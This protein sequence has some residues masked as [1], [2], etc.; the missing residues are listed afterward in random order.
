MP[1]P[2]NG[3][4]DVSQCA[5]VPSKEE[6]T[7]CL[8]R[9]DAELRDA[10]ER[11][12]SVGQQLHSMRD[13]VV[14]QTKPRQGSKGVAAT[15]GSL[16]LQDP[17]ALT[18]H[19]H[20]MQNRKAQPE[21]RFRRASGSGAQGELQL[22]LH[23][24]WMELST[25]AGAEVT[26]KDKT[27][28][29]KEAL[30]TSSTRD[31]LEKLMLKSRTIKVFHPQGFFK[32]CWD[33][34]ALFLLI[35]DAITIPPS[36]AWDVKMTQPTF[37]GWY[38]MISFWMS[39]IFWSFDF[40]INLNTAVY[41]KGTLQSGRDKI[42]W[43]YLTTWMP[44]DLLLIGFD[45]MF[46][47]FD[48]GDTNLAVVR[49]ARILRVLRMIRLIKL[50]KL[51]NL[52][53]ESAAA[54]GRQW[55]T[56]VVAITKTGVGMILVAHWLTCF[57]YWTGMFLVDTSIPNWIEENE[58][59]LVAGWIQYL[60]ALRWI[61]N[62]PSPPEIHPAS[63]VE[64]A[65]DIFISVVTLVVIGS[66]ISKISGTMA[67]L[68][69]MNEETS[70]RR[71]EVRLY[72]ASQAVSY[73]LV[74]RI[75][76]F[77]DYKLEKVS[78]NNMDATLISPTLQL[79]LYINQRADYLSQM[80][81]FALA[82]ECYPEVFGSLCA[83]FTK[84]FYEKGESVFTAGSYATA[85]HL[86]YV[87]KYEYAPEHED[88][89]PLDSAV[90]WFGELS[91][92]V[93]P[94]WHSS[95]LTATSFAETFSLQGEDLVEC[96]KV[97][98]GCTSMFCE[99]AKDFLAGM[100]KTKSK[101]G[102][103]DQKIQGDLCC[104]HNQHFQAAYPDPTTLFKNIV[105]CRDH[106]SEKS[107]E[108]AEDDKLTDYASE[109]S[110]LS[111]LSDQ[112]GG[113][114]SFHNLDEIL[115][116][117]GLAHFASEWISS[118][119]DENAVNLPQKLQ[120]V[121]PELDKE[122][123]THVVFGQAPE[124]DR[125][126]SACISVL[127]LVRN[128]YDVFTKPQADNV[129]LLESQ[130]LELQQIVSWIEPEPEELHAVLVLLAIRGLGKS[131]AVMQQ[132]PTE[133]RRPERAVIHLS[134]NHQNVIPSTRWLTEKGRG[135][136]EE[137]LLTH[138]LFNL[139]QMLQGE[140]CP[141]NVKELHAHIEEKGDSLFR[142]YILFL[143]GFMSGL[144]G[145]EGSRFMNAKNADAT[146]GGIRVLQKLM[147]VNA[148]AIYWGYLN[149]RAEKLG[150][151]FNDPEDLVLVRLACL[152]RVQDQ[153]GYESLRFAWLALGT[154]E[155]SSLTDHFLADGIEERAFNLEFLPN[156]VGNAKANPLI[157]LTLLLDVLTDL[158]ASLRTK[159]AMNPKMPKLVSVDLSDMGE[160]ISAV[161]NRFVFATC[162][163]R[164]QMKFHQGRVRIEMT[165]G[166][167]GRATD[168]DSDLTSI[169]YTLQ[170]LVIK[171]QRLEERL[172]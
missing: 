59:S 133:L 10:S 131:K 152:A 37:G 14:G 140:N 151:P 76:R 27:R 80:P 123:G 20:Q 158:L 128:K 129:K 145:G 63:G 150:L 156:C 12:A 98:R 70:R 170:D 147:S 110:V 81:I 11:L 34:I 90:R 3:V 78:A 121:I 40:P 107:P 126:E 120:V 68:R 45:Y 105:I 144:A 1:V 132:V 33:I 26:V 106:D 82:Q 134:Q 113:T 69:A 172:L 7:Q 77:V 155:R 51:N 8:D 167:W 6:L 5:V 74:T 41:V 79:E 56:M 49:S 141:A 136:F 43:M 44:F 62:A 66:A 47:S 165:G 135:L 143:L 64:R 164:C 139:A 87:G 125:G 61:L 23:G 19:Q 15:S 148:T 163:S 83:A 91:L 94:S 114:R 103:E 29:F 137:A 95:T 142:F 88:P 58:A 32:L 24:R 13:V 57:W 119:Q 30:S 72:L 102:D 97:N 159:A 109:K 84:T 171:Q 25:H 17:P 153:K 124:R 160:F 16:L 122:F 31:D 149:L 117:Q 116:D 65:V 52:I 89:R 99:Y 21:P 60:H 92:Y 118:D 71:R 86:T 115:E 50:S 36:L 146:I 35:N 54:A 38:V 85:L 100:Q 22:R 127:A 53:E 2:S 18:L 28:K 138:E 112:S 111:R 166:N 104:R 168:S 169:A 108:G 130:W 101:F 39:L 4:S 93:D 75:M 157:G 161:R 96:I 48:L 42:L 67:E 162:I 9:A 73:E 46:I 55:V 154:R